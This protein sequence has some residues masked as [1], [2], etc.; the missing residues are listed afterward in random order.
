M[1]YK[2]TH[3]KK[4]SAI[5]VQHRN[6]FI[7]YARMRRMVDRS[8]MLESRG[9][10]KRSPYFWSINCSFWVK[11]Y[12]IDVSNVRRGDVG[13]DNEPPPGVCTASL[14]RFGDSV[15]NPRRRGDP[16][17]LAFDILSC[18]VSS[19]PPP[20]SLV[21]FIRPALRTHNSSNARVYYILY[22]Q[23]LSLSIQ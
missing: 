1:K 3:T 22:D 6:A 9:N 14:P 2:R 4:P 11:V 13:A 8:L 12:C 20:P 17:S 21:T 15:R 7:W 23:L 16:I 10:V 5:S 18:L 19:T